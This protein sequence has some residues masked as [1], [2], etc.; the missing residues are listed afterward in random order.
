MI[1]KQAGSLLRNSSNR[2]MAVLPLRRPL[3]FSPIS[4]FGPCSREAADRFADT[5][6]DTIRASPRTD[7]APILPRP[8]LR[9]RPPAREYGCPPREGRSTLPDDA[10]VP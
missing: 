9:R 4:E 3:N 6:F 10:P 8:P 2:S 1:S 7:Q 5:L